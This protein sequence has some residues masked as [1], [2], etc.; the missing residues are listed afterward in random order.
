LRIEAALIVG[1]A[2]LCIVPDTPVDP[3]ED[4]LACARPDEDEACEQMVNCLN[5]DAKLGRAV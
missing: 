3:F 1:F 5:G 2:S 4:E